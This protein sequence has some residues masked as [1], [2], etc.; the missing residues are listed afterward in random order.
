MDVFRRTT[1]GKLPTPDWRRTFGLL[2]ADSSGCTAQLDLPSPVTPGVR[3]AGR[4]PAASVSKLKVPAWTELIETPV[5]S[6]ATDVRNML[7][8]SISAPWQSLD[9]VGVLRG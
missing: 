1:Q 7:L 8:A 4:D 9:A 2:G 5:M 6:A 3:P